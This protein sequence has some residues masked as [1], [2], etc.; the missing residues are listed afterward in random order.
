MPEEESPDIDQ[1]RTI[2]AKG[3]DRIPGFDGQPNPHSIWRFFKVIAEIVLAEVDEA[4]PSRLQV[5]GWP[6]IPLDPVTR[7]A[8]VVQIVEIFNAVRKY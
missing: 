6:P 3:V 5:S 8:G 2:Q 4:N 7:V 1:V